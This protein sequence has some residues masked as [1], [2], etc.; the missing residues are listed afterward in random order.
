MMKQ[1]FSSPDS[2]R[3]GFIRSLLDAA[4]IASEV[5]NES[6]SQAI[7]GFPFAP[8]LWFGDEDYEDAMRLVAGSHSRK[9]Q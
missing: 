7:P 2:A 8:E 9:N 4:D 1:I 3:V 5:R 6:V